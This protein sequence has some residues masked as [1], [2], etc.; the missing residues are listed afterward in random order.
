MR[1]SCPP[2]SADWI[3][4]GRSFGGSFDL[5]GFMTAVY[6]VGSDLLNKGESPGKDILGLR[7][8]SLGDGAEL[9][10]ER[11][12][13]RTL[14]KLLSI[15]MLP[16]AAFLYVWKS[17]GFTLQDFLVGTTVRSAKLLKST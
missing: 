7:T 1:A 16:V 3:W 14:L 11:S 10:Y 15:W 5:Y 6:F 2:V 12:L 13:G 4:Y 8:V 17:R 9:S